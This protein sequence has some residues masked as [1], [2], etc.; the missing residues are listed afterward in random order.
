MR[1]T[2]PL[3]RE[4]LAHY[5]CSDT[6]YMGG[7]ENWPSAQRESVARLIEL[8]LLFQTNLGTH[9]KVTANR[10]ALSVYMDALAAV[11]LP[12]RAWIIPAKEA[13]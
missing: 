11:P 12:I 1:V 5:H 13:T 10:E 8:G 3:E 6:P 4:I 7:S 9:W 2:S